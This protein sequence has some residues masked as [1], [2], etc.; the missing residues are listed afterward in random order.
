MDQMHR[1]KHNFQ[2]L[3][4]ACYTGLNDHTT[5]MKHAEELSKRVKEQEAQ[6]LLGGKLDRR[7]KQITPI[8]SGNDVSKASLQDARPPPALSGP[9]P[10]DT[11]PNETSLALV[12][13]PQPEVQP[14]ENP[15]I[16]G[17]LAESWFGWTSAPAAPPTNTQ[18][19]A[20]AVQTRP[21]PQTLQPPEGGQSVDP[22]HVNNSRDREVFYEDDRDE[23]V[24]RNRSGRSMHAD[25]RHSSHHH[26]HHG[27]HG[28]PSRH[29]HQGNRGHQGNHSHHDRRRQPHQYHGDDDEDFMD[30]PMHSHNNGRIYT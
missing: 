15:G 7:S 10:T 23:A 28:H 14:R 8:R 16:F 5:F 9:P 12:P 30:P 24:Y 18:E 22:D 3:L 17:K 26:G 1:A 13:L 19:Q 4:A 29:G 27:H 20:L 2:E 21:L 25:H 6:G 11:M